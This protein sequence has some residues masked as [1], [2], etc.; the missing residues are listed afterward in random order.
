MSLMTHD[1]S[2]DPIFLY[3]LLQTPLHRRFQRERRPWVGSNGLFAGAFWS[4]IM[5]TAAGKFDI[6]LDGHSAVTRTVESI[7]RR[8]AHRGGAGGL[9][10]K[11]GGKGAM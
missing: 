7:R 5:R 1:A 2:D 8:V 3:L 11:E 9:G 10:A 6:R 4:R